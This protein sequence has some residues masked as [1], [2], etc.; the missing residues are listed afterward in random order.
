MDQ[1][2]VNDYPIIDWSV[3]PPK[4]TDGKYP[5]AGGT[6][7]QVTLGVY[8]PIT[9]QTVFLNTGTPKDHYLTC[10]TWS[11]DEQY[12]FI[13]LLNREQNHLWLNKYNARTGAFINTL[14]EETDP[15][16]VEPQHALTFLPDTD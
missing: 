7:H 4:N 15:E 5:M 6:S 8:N 16:Y 11:P 3:T 1:T 12:I 9:K 10:V 2:M 14:F 13:A